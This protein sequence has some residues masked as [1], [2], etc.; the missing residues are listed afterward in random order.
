MATFVVRL[1]V[2][3]ARF[4]HGAFDDNDLATFQQYCVVTTDFAAKAS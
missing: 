3:S 4:F 2:T 1:I